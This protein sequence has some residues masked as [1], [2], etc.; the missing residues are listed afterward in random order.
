MRERLPIQL[1]GKKGGEIGLPK[2][3]SFHV[4]LLVNSKVPGTM[5]LHT[6]FE[7][8]KDPG[9]VPGEIQ[10]LAGWRVDRHALTNRVSCGQRSQDH[11]YLFDQSNRELTHRGKRICKRPL[12]QLR[13]P[14][15]ITPASRQR[16]QRFSPRASARPGSGTTNSSRHN[17]SGY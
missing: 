9:F 14:L 1:H 3:V 5:A 7:A 12:Q 17:S 10:P 8:R 11:R 4:T 13:Q 15:V 16:S 6:V 2:C